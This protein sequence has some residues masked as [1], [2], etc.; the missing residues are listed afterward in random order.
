MIPTYGAEEQ[1]LSRPWVN[2]EGSGIRTKRG[3][4]IFFSQHTP[5]TLNSGVARYA[6]HVLL[7]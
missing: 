4:A 2:G 7:L 5:L 1:E 6:R 3:M